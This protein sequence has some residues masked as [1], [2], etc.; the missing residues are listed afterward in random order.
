MNRIGILAAGNLIVD[1]VK[2]VDKWPS[3]GMLSNV[4]HEERSTGG[5]P[6]NVLIDLAKME[7]D[8]PLFVAGIVGADP[9]GEYVKK[10]LTSFKIDTSQI[11]VTNEAST[12]FTDVMSDASTGR[13][14]F[15]HYRGANRLLNEEHLKDL[16]SNARIFHLAYLLLLDAL[17]QA[18]TELGVVAARVL[19]QKRAQGYLVSVDV[20]SES[21][22]GFQRV[23]TPCLKY[24]DYLI[25]NEIEAGRSSGLQ[26]REA[27]DN[28]NV[29][30]LKKAGHILLEGG[31]QKL[32]AIHFPE[33]C[34][35]LTSTREEH[36]Q[37]SFVVS[38]SEMKGSVGAG[39]AFCAGL[40]YGLHEGLD[41]A[42]ALNLAHASA[43]FNLTSPTCSDGA[44]PLS[45]LV[46]FVESSRPRTPIPEGLEELT[47][48]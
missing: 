22:E 30:N 44:V 3:E 46:N 39:D 34:Y 17:D 29:D 45:Q 14:T 36:Y 38:N 18:D 11:R 2:V 33:G 8:I 23:V 28:L 40:L 16:R 6:S 24:I 47:D 9:D 19:S 27:D 21:T 32:V 15:F 1:H 13:R 7:V 20:V 48:V 35:A 25:L 41:L 10:R 5:G 31:V 26:I 37:P 43:R 4:L 42:V 12:S